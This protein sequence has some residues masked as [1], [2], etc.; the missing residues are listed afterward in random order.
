M[1]FDEEIIALRREFHTCPELGMEN[2][3]TAELI[4]RSLRSIGINDIKA[5]LGEGTGISA[6]IQGTKEGMCLAL[7]ADTDSLPIFEETGLPFASRLF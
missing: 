7:H 3:A 1:Q 5:G 2:P 6:V 4:I